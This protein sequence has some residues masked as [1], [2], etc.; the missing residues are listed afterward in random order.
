MEMFKYNS[1]RGVVTTHL[2]NSVC[3]Y[4]YTIYPNVVKPL[5]PLARHNIA[6]AGW[7]TEK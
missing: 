6:R 7:L 2:V 3:V 5:I 4:V 1:K